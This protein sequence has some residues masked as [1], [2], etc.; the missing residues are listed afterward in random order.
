MLIVHYLLHHRQQNPLESKK[1]AIFEEHSW[2]QAHNVMS[3][4]FPLSASVFSKANDV[5][6]SILPATLGWW[7]DKRIH[8]RE[9]Y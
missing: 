2:Y 9:A 6:T 4:F 7:K 8:L 5:E 3:G 1:A